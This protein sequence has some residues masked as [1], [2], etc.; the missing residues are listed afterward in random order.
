MREFTTRLSPAHG[1]AQG[2]GEEDRPDGLQPRRG[3]A[4]SSASR[5]T[6]ATTLI[7]VVPDPTRRRSRPLHPQRH[8]D[9]LQRGRRPV[10]GP[11]GPRG[12]R[13]SSSART[14]KSSAW[15]SPTRTATAHR[16]RERLRQATPFGA[17]A[18]QRTGER[19]DG[20]ER[21]RGQ[22]SSEAGAERRTVKTAAENRRPTRPACVTAAS[23]AAGRGQGC[24]GD[25]Q[26]R[27]GRGHH[28]R[29]RRRRDHAHHARTAW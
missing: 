20:D 25:R 28:Q 9:P 24:E 23:A 1:H 12:A 14:T 21:R 4:A 13:G 29:P 15:S 26:E 11:Q 6:K 17:N 7:D 2:H 16:V 3:R 22:A 10:D 8:G 27:P 18:D 19:A 5:S